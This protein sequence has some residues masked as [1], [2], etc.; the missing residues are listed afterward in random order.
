MKKALEATLCVAAK[1]KAKPSIVPEK[2][3]EEKKPEKKAEEKKPEE[4]KEEK[5]PEEK[6]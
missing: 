2:K 5:K 6:K 1:P 4:K 3:A